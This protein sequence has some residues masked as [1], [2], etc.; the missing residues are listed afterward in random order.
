MYLNCVLHVSY[1]PLQLECDRQVEKIV[2]QFH[3]ERLLDHKVH[4]Y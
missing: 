1:C 2:Q 4:T 3:E